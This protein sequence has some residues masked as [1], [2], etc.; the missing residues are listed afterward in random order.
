M[1]GVGRWFKSNFRKKS[2]GW[3]K[4]LVG[5]ISGWK[6]RRSFEEFLEK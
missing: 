1:R 4:N 6:I 5:R 2:E 3:W